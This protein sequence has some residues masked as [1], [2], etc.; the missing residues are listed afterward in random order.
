MLTYFKGLWRAIKGY[1]DQQELKIPYPSSFNPR[2]K[3]DS[4]Y[5]QLRRLKEI[6]AYREEI[7]LQAHLIVELIKNIRPSSPNYMELI[8]RNIGQLIGLE[9]CLNKLPNLKG[10]VNRGE[11]NA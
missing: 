8:H 9:W 1:N 3:T 11:H 10:K 7:N 4:Y 2:L 6:P 5:E